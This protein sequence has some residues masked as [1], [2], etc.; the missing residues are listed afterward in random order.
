M[1]TH[2]VEATLPTERELNWLREGASREDSLTCRVKVERGALATRGHRL[3]T[4]EQTWRM[5][6]D[7]PFLAR[8][9]K[10]DDLL[11][12]ITREFRERLIRKGAFSA[13][14]A[15]TRATLGY[16]DESRQ[17]VNRE[18]QGRYEI[19][20]CTGNVS[21][22]DGEVFVHAHVVL[23]GHDY[24]CVAGHLM[25]GTEIFAAELYGT[26]VPGDV[27]VRAFDEPTGLALWSQRGQSS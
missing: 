16:Y 17:Y 10:G 19:A 13:I 4:P 9:P 15:V 25:P 6:M 1:A 18:F 14:G 11:E 20:A 23:S 2:A 26:P 7:G 22:K 21:E 8:L 24:G 5:A 3:N 12:A 27:P